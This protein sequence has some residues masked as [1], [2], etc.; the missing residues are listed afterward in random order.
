MCLFCFRYDL[1]HF[2][3][4][5]Q[6]VVYLNRT[7]I[8]PS[9][10]MQLW[11]FLFPVAVFIVRGGTLCVQ[12]GSLYTLKTHTT[13]TLS[14][15]S[16]IWAPLYPAKGFKRLLC[17]SSLYDFRCQSVFSSRK[18]PVLMFILAGSPPSL[19]HRLKMDCDKYLR[20]PIIAVYCVFSFVNFIWSCG[21]KMKL[22]QASIL[23]LTG[24][25]CFF[26]H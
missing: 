13:Q 20:L 9:S 10:S 17:C 23:Y 6:N 25:F 4:P 8:V 16:A 26:C 14:S 11:L 1:I 19:P 2:P 5:A 15:L 12:K 18:W 24:P 3:L 7:L 21:E 22:L